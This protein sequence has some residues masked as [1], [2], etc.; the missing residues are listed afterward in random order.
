MFF[1]VLR[2]IMWSKYEQWEEQAEDLSCFYDSL[3]LFKLEYDVL[4]SNEQILAAC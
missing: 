2:H 1:H 4:L 3:G